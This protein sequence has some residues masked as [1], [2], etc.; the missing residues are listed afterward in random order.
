M[1]DTR[2]GTTPLFLSGLLP[3]F[4]QPATGQLLRDLAVDH[5]EFFVLDW[6]QQ[7]EPGA[8]RKGL[9][10]VTVPGQISKASFW[11]EGAFW[12]VNKQAPNYG[13]QNWKVRYELPVHSIFLSKKGQDIEKKKEMSKQQIKSNYCTDMR[14]Q[15]FLFNLGPISCKKNKIKDVKIL[16]FCLQKEKY[17]VNPKLLCIVKLVFQITDSCQ[18]L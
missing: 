13:L 14:F 6:Y 9:C 2:F 17:P 18:H 5:T 8:A 4:L 11:G 1:V 3:R 10:E 16:W 12:G 7:K 15:W